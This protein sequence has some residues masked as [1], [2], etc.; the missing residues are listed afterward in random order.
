MGGSYA[1]S[2]LGFSGSFA[3]FGDTEAAR[4]NT[5]LKYRLNLPNNLFGLPGASF[6]LGGLW[7]WG[8]YDQGN[9]TNGMYQGQVGRDFKL[10]GGAP[11]AGTLSMD[12]IGSWAKDE[13]NLSTFTGTCTTLTKGPFAG[14]TGC[15]SGLP[16][17]YANTDLKATLSNNT[18]FLFTAKYK[19]Q[20]LTVYGGYAWLSRRT[21]ATTFRTAS[22]PS[23]DGTFPRPSPRSAQPSRNS[24]RRNGSSPTTTISRGSPPTGG[25]AQIRPHTSARRNRRLLLPRPNQLQHHPLR[26]HPL[27]NCRTKR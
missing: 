21:R 8:G 6:R 18:G 22:G 19:W 1:F 4:A 7:Q 14:E 25:S 5:A 27:H 17:F 16:T 23:A 2:P 12:A 15:T 10:F 9:G 24:F 26:R 3:G 20:G 13:V 11:W